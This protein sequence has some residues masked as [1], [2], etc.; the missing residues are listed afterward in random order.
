[1]VDRATLDTRGSAEVFQQLLLNL[2]RF[3]LKRLVV[4]TAVDDV[5][6]ASTTS[7]GA[8]SRQSTSREHAETSSAAPNATKR[9]DI[10]ALSL[11]T[12]LVVQAEPESSSDVKKRRAGSL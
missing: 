4:T 8:G 11:T 6:S 1:V 12:R 5:M 10:G 9:G 7:V 2:V 3:A